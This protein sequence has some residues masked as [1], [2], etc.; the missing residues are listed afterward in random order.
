MFYVGCALIVLA[1]YAFSRLLRAYLAAYADEAI[2]QMKE[3]RRG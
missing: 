1:G 2:R 3:N